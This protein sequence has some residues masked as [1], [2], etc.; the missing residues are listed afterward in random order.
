MA[1]ASSAAYLTTPPPLFTAEG[2]AADEA[3]SLDAYFEAC[4]AS[5]SLSSSAAHE[6]EEEDAHGESLPSSGAH[7]TAS[8]TELFTASTGSRGSFTH[9][10]PLQGNVPR[11]LLLRQRQV[12]GRC[13]SG[14]GGDVSA[15]LYEP[16]GL[17][18]TS[19]DLRPSKRKGTVTPTGFSNTHNADLVAPAVRGTAGQDLADQLH[20]ASLPL[21]STDAPWRSTHDGDAAAAATAKVFDFYLPT[22]S[23]ATAP[24]SNP[25]QSSSSKGKRRSTTTITTRGRSSRS[26]SSPCLESR[27]Q[28]HARQ[29]AVLFDVLCALRQHPTASCEALGDGDDRAGAQGR[30]VLSKTTWSLRESVKAEARAQHWPPSFVGALAQLLAVASDVAVA[31]AQAGVFERVCAIRDAAAASIAGTTGASGDTQ[32]AAGALE[33]AGQQALQRLSSVLRQLSAD[34]VQWVLQV[35]EYLVVV[36]ADAFGDHRTTQTPQ[37]AA[38]CSADAHT[39]WYARSEGGRRIARNVPASDSRG[40]NNRHAEED[41]EGA[42]QAAPESILP[43][44][45][46]LLDVVLAVQENGIPLQRC[47]VLVDES[48]CFDGLADLLVELPC[49]STS[50]LHS[51]VSFAA[52]AARLLDTLIIQASAVQDT[53]T[54]DLYRFYVMLLLLTAWPYVL[55]CTAAIFG[56]VRNIDPPVWRRQL[57][58]LFRSSF[59]HV[60]IGDAHRHY[61]TDV[62]SL[63]LNCVGYYNASEVCNARSGGVGDCAGGLQPH[64][65]LGKGSRHSSSSS[66]NGGRHK[67]LAEHHVALTALSSARTFVLRSLASFTRRKKQVALSRTPARPSPVGQRK[68]A[69]AAEG[70]GNSSD[71]AAAAAMAA[72]PA[73]L[74]SAQRWQ[75]KSVK[76][77][78]HY[79]L[80]GSGGRGGGND[81]DQGED[82]NGEEEQERAHDTT[83]AEKGGDIGAGAAVVAYARANQD[84]RRRVIQLPQNTAEAPVAAGG[85]G[86]AVMLPPPP[87]RL[88]PDGARYFY[89]PTTIPLGFATMAAEALAGQQQWQ[90]H[91]S[92]AVARAEV[93]ASAPSP[94]AMRRPLRHYSDHDEEDGEKGE[95]E[96]GSGGS[97]PLE[98]G[99]LALWTLFLSESATA[100][101]VVFANAFAPTDDD[102]A[103]GDDRRSLSRRFGQRSLRSARRV[104]THQLWINITIPCARWVTT[105][106]LIPIGVVVQRLQERRLRDLFAMSLHAVSSHGPR[107]ITGSHD[108]DGV[109]SRRGRD[110]SGVLWQNNEDEEEGSKSLPGDV[111]GGVVA[112]AFTD[113]LT[114]PSTTASAA[115]AAG[116]AVLMRRRGAPSSVP[117]S[118]TTAA[119][120][121][122]HALKLLV[123]VALCRDQE[124]LVFGFL[125]RLYKEPR[126]WTRRWVDGGAGAFE[127]VGTA[128]PTVSALFADALRGKRL[129]ELVRLVVLPASKARKDRGSPLASSGDPTPQQ[130]QQQHPQTP[131]VPLSRHTPAAAPT[132]TIST[133]VLDVFASFQLE[134]TLPGAFALVLQ[135]SDLS[136]HV[137][138]VTNTTERSY[139]TF[140][141]QR[142]RRQYVEEEDAAAPPTARLGIAFSDVWSY[143]FGYQC[144]LYYAQITLREHK[145][146]LHQRDTEDFQ[147]TQTMGQPRRGAA[148][149]LQYVARGLG[150]AYYTLNFAVDTLLSFTQAEAMRA[151]YD[152][153]HLL[154]RAL[155]ASPDLHSCMEL[156]HEL[157]TLLL[158]LHFIS[159]PARPAVALNARERAM[160]SPAAEAIRSA[161][162]RLL[163]VALDP[164]RLPVSYISSSTRNSV[165]ALVA[166]VTAAA[167]HQSALAT[168]LH[169]LRVMLTF[170]KY[171][172]TPEETLSYRFR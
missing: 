93:E 65:T 75:N 4:R 141:W 25:S 46:S 128:A 113:P 3:G 82:S 101:D 37:Q 72:A 138:A 133:D 120:S 91:R 50:P 40:S 129:S 165:E 58:R 28:R 27:A 85:R 1:A 104:R 147:V 155:G 154:H 111:G 102:D 36:C 160:Q 38:L 109:R 68:A 157:D 13:S 49:A 22:P 56:F 163:E 172:G 54:M 130:Q 77:I 41:Q 12:V 103:D 21:A 24:P 33:D 97:G 137:Q 122:L 140:F 87:P 161:V 131:G 124:R 42:A 150:S 31:Q 64:W 114:P 119:C 79:I 142:R 63:L 158:Q 10:S 19:S 20:H 152:I 99:A 71:R 67:D 125:E 14:S 15:P 159:F 55:L 134:F 95:G 146:Q 29:R 23:P 88:T 92:R 11:P 90:Q 51:S 74:L 52:L 18:A 62:L 81:G 149:H 78:L 89:Y 132:S 126:W 123:D 73:P 86:A 53:S 112:H 148:R 107:S 105:A 70:G 153:E 110:W 164:S 156:C 30:A 169:P 139:Q 170:N 115:P 76:E 26:P 121:F 16:E 117:A 145:K 106:L 135:P 96:T 162:Q 59:S 143:I 48:G 6:E 98:H 39:H 2:D 5:S 34:F 166:A 118:P 45:H 61:P 7:R 8:A 57:P 60:R 168:R 69:T 108:P 9:F 167:E 136:V 94:P 44:S 127:R 66:S 116:G 32:D 84:V 83:A 17:P 171:Y 43:P 35:Q 151:V 100:P 47:R 144:S 80:Y